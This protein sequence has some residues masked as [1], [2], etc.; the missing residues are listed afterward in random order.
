MKSLFVN[1]HA[2]MF[3]TFLRRHYPALM[4]LIVPAVVWLPVCWYDFVSLDDQFNVYENVFITNFS[5]TNLVYFW[6][7]VFEFLYIPLTYSLWGTIAK[8][9]QFV[10]AE[11]PGVVDPHFFHTANLL[12]HLLNTAVLFIIFRRMLDDEWGAAVGALLFAIHP[13]QAEA[14]AW[15]T[16]MKDLLNGFCSLMCLWFYL[17]YGKT[18][19]LGRK[20]W[21]LYLTATIFYLFALLSKPTAVILPLTAAVIGRFWLRKTWRRL[22]LELLPWVAMALPII[23]VTQSVQEGSVLHFVP[24]YWQRVLVSGDAV[25]FYLYKL[26]LPLSLAFDY[27]RSPQYV[28]GQNW[29]YLTGLLPFVLFLFLYW[30]ARWEWLLIG[31][32]LLVVPLLPVLGLVTFNFQLIST[33][34]DRYLY[35]AVLGPAYV[36]GWLL[37]G[38]P[39]RPVKIVTLVILALLSIR[40]SMQIPHWANSA[41]LYRHTLLVN[42][43]SWISYNNLGSITLNQGKPEAALSYFQKSLDIVPNAK[44]Y[45]A[46]G[47]AYERLGNYPA[48]SAAYGKALELE[49][50][51]GEAYYRL[52]FVY[53]ANGN[54]EEGLEFFKKAVEV[55]P[56][57]LRTA[58]FYAALGMSFSEIGNIDWAIHAYQ[59]ALM[60]NPY[61][62]GVHSALGNLYLKRN[63]TGKAQEMFEKD[64]ALHP[65]DSQP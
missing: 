9:S 13:V 23:Y 3:L 41:A 42:Q 47:T 40:T 60:L 7:G 56:G 44:T 43:N 61:L 14:V 29:V 34:A 1:N 12:V 39:S 55:S 17:L 22:L 54:K 25:T 58:V 53:R 20:P 24:N 6:S 31:A 52:G 27:G 48:A 26:F 2:V 38:H 32:G 21:L 18:K 5:W 28:L 57:L 8:F 46:L 35:L 49:P 59:K 36:L 33:V 30:K 63:E 64:R 11:N 62:S 15:V 10:H 50:K 4:V 37:S 45:L 51:Y 65:G 16:G 19:P